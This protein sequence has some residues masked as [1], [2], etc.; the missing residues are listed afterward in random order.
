MNIFCG[1]LIRVAVSGLGLYGNIKED[2]AISL[3]DLFSALYI[4]ILSVQAA[5]AIKT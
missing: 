4:G 5:W 1:A 2:L 3:E